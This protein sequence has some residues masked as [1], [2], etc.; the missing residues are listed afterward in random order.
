LPLPSAEQPELWVSPDLSGRWVIETRDGAYQPTRNGETIHAGGQSW[1]LQLPT[2]LEKTV[3]AEGVAGEPVTEIGLR[4]MVS[5]DRKYVE[6]DVLLGDR[7]KHFPPRA[8]HHVLL[9]LARKRLADQTDPALASV[10]AS[11]HG[12]IAIDE[13]R[14]M[15]G[16]TQSKLD[17]DIFR[18]RQQLGD[19]TGLMDARRLIERRRGAQIRLNVSRIEIID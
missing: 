17:L 5:R 16:A 10:P 14:R 9:A 12:W 1:R 13:L 3:K 15:L 7:C 6:I 11:E 19:E 8:H 2:V 18:A 4:F